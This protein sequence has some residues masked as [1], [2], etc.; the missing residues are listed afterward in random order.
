MF[1]KL[2]IA[3]SHSFAAVF[4]YVWHTD[5]HNTLEISNAIAI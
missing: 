3:I 5:N 4:L 2:F 1:S